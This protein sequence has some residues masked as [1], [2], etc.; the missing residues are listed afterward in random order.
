MH[1]KSIKG[2]YV[3]FIICIP[4]SKSFDSFT[5][6]TK[7]Y[8][9]TELYSIPIPANQTHDRFHFL[10]ILISSNS[11]SINIIYY[12]LIQLSHLLISLLFPFIYWSKSNILY[13]ILTSLLGLQISVTCKDNDLNLEDDIIQHK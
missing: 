3:I 13:L 4:K 7:I 9:G 5:N 11:N 12:L 2:P 1:K 6:Q 10:H 8:N